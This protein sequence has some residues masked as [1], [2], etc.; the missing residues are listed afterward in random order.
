M[1]LLL[2]FNTSTHFLTQKGTGELL[3]GLFELLYFMEIQSRPY[4]Y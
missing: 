2:H 4:Y 3:F 1:F